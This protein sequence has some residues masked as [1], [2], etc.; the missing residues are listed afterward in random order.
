MVSCVLIKQ[1]PVFSR[2][3]TANNPPDLPQHT[4]VICPVKP[5]ANWYHVYV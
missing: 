3:A 5:A 4:C 2:N 1:K